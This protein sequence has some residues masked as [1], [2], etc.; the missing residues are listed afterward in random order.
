MSTTATST[1]AEL[2]AAHKAL[3]AAKHTLELARE[4]Y[5]DAYAAYQLS[6][7]AGKRSLANQ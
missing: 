3:E 4:R 2:Y 6:Q 1:A 5:E 7:V